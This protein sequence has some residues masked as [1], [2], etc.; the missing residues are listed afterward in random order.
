RHA[1]LVLFHQQLDQVG[2]EICVAHSLQDATGMFLEVAELLG[3]RISCGEDPLVNEQLL[4][5]R[6]GEDRKILQIEISD[7]WWKRQ[8]GPLEVAADRPGR[9]RDEPTHMTS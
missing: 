3:V 6:L 9:C 8:E 1:H 4:L 2:L 5:K 7:F